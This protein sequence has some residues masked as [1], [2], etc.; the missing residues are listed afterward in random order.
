MAAVIL[1]VIPSFFLFQVTQ[2]TVFL[3]LQKQTN[4]VLSKKYC[5]ADHDT[6]KNIL[7]N[8]RYHFL[9]LDNVGK[10]LQ[11]LD[12]LCFTY[13]H[14]GCSSTLFKNC[15]S[16]KKIVKSRQ[17]FDDVQRALFSLKKKHK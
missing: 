12:A 8:W 4:K 16:G 11:K 13:Q 9:L 14:E 15:F 17:V 10:P 1:H 3:I 6:R 2:K 7:P 5:I